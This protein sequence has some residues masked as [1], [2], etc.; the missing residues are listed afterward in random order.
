MSGSVGAVERKRS[1]GRSEVLIVEVSMADGEEGVGV[2]VTVVA[3]SFEFVEEGEPFPLEDDGA[4]ARK[5]RSR[6]CII[7][8]VDAAAKTTFWR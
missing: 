2:I 3:G 6:L 7:G 4:D 8:D 5:V 1:K